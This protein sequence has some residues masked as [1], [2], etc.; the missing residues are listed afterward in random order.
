M[1]PCTTFNAGR[2]VL[3]FE[4]VRLSAMHRGVE[5]SLTRIGLLQAPA[6]PTANRMQ[7]GS[8]QRPP[9][10]PPGQQAGIGAPAAPTTAGKESSMAGGLI[11]TSSLPLGMA[12]VNSAKEDMS[13]WTLEAEEATRLVRQ[14]Y[15][16][17]HSVPA[18]VTSYV[19]RMDAD[20]VSLTFSRFILSPIA[21]VPPQWITRQHA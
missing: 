19:E 1:L 20:D 2:L 8:P 18:A 3:S 7:T 17:R 10:T 4:A 9:P 12:A 14:R 5:F 11:K 15:N 13:R 21:L 6:P 16:G